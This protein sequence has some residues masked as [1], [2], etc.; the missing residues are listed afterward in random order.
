MNV[1]SGEFQ[2]AMDVIG[3]SLGLLCGF[4][5]CC[6]IALIRI[7]IDVNAMRWRKP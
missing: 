1:T 3:W 2:Q 7:S 5:A 4:A 6:M